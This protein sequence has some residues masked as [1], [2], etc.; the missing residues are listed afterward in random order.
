LSQAIKSAVAYERSVRT[1]DYSASV[2]L[3][4]VLA[5]DVVFETNG[6]G[7]TAVQEKTEGKAAV[8][9]RL[10]GKWAITE[11]LYNAR[12]SEPVQ[13][14]STVRLKATFEHLGGVAPDSL[15][16]TI[17]TDAAGK[18]KRI[19]QAYTPRQAKPTDRIP[20]SA[21]VLINNA[22]MNN[23]PF[24]VAHVDENGAP[25]VTFRGSVQVLDDH[26]L[27]AWI[28]QASGGIVKSLAKNP[29]V[30]LAYRDG[31]RAMLLVQGRASIDTSEEMKA[32]VYE[33]TPEVE[34]NHDPARK[35]VPM[36]IEID[37]MQ[38]F[39]TGGEPVRMV[40]QRQG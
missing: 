3:E 34:Q 35:G 10:S 24:V 29:A 19:Q 38:G 28:R 27:C 18:I 6:P 26:R 13:E 15:A 2:A 16:V 22:R 25:V 14:G 8:L 7:A 4:P 1:G 31:S 30:A 11:S 36:I 37:R 12:W 17:E 32:R 33:L 39:S 40:R 21:K 23:T 20:E 5:G 9:K